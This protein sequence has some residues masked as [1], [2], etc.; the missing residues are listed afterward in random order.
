MEE[1]FHELPLWRVDHFVWMIAW[2]WEIHMGMI[3][4]KIYQISF[5]KKASRPHIVASMDIPLVHDESH[6]DFSPKAYLY[7]WEEQLGDLLMRQH[8]VHWRSLSHK[9]ATRGRGEALQFY[10]CSFLRT[11]NNWEVRSVIFLN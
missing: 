5:L 4:S 10:P 11:N 7:T 6:L 1:N 2:G 3:V 9:D 8:L